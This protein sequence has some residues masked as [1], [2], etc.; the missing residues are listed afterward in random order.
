[1]LKRTWI[2]LMVLSL[3]GLMTLPVVAYAHNEA[4]NCP[5]D[6]NDNRHPSG[7]D[8]SCESGSSEDGSTGGSAQDHEGDSDTSIQGNSDSDPD[9]DGRGPD[10]SN[11]GSD[12]PNGG[13]GGL[14]HADQD[15]NNGCGNDD[16]F[17]DDNE[18]WCGGKPKPAGGEGQVEVQ[19]Q[20]DTSGKG[21]QGGTTQVQGKADEAG[22]VRS[23]GTAESVTQVLG[24]SFGRAAL[25]TA[26]PTVVLG[27]EFVRGQALAVTGTP[28]GVMA[29]I[30]LTLIGFGAVL[31]RAS[32]VT[33]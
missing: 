26:A 9:D 10:R 8:R 5:D 31:V 32:R 19:G 28:A 1:M 3:V 27:V 17:E 11:G 12:K 20:G 33:V 23:L 14:D 16:D 6:A 21:A 22:E 18:G 4:Q 15:S 13:V 2:I 29:L 30:A 7:K 25:P 24:E